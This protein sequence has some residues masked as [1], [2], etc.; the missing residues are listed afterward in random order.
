MLTWRIYMFIGHLP[1]GYLL[2]R[3]V[4]K[5]MPS[6]QPGMAVVVSAA[7]VGG[8]L[9]DLDLIYFYT[10]GGKQVV[11]H[12]YWSHTPFYWFVIYLCMSFATFLIRSM[13]AFKILSV[14]FSAIVLHLALDT[15]TGQ[16]HWLHPVSKTTFNLVQVPAVHSWWV[17]NFLLHWT[18]ALEILVLALA[19]ILHVKRK[20]A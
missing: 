19:V 5:V 20:S 9:P 13:S 3:F 14:I 10:I 2:G 12:E 8:V 6:T 16:I 18:F 4:C 17:A 15:I 7:L 1:A 11:H